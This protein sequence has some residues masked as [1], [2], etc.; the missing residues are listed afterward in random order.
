MMAWISPGSTSSV[1]TAQDGGVFNGDV[2]VFDVEHRTLSVRVDAMGVS[3]RLD[4]ISSVGWGQYQDQSGPFVAA[5]K[6]HVA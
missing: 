3:W 2:E 5:G 6:G 1:D 4:Y